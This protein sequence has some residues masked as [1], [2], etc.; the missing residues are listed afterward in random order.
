MH[1]EVLLCHGKSK[2]TTK[3]LIIRSFEPIGCMSKS[4]FDKGKCSEP[5]REVGDKTFVMTP[6]CNS[7]P[8]AGTSISRIT[9]VD[10]FIIRG[11][12]TTMWRILY[13]KR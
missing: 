1:G 2:I 12:H 5:L 9:D 8:T 6:I 7:N 13:R 4:N 10:R 3:N 11:D